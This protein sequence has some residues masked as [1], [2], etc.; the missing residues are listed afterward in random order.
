ML[1]HK[2]VQ[3]RGNDAGPATITPSKG[4]AGTFATINNRLYLRDLN[5][6][7]IRKLP[8]PLSS[9]LMQRLE[10][11]NAMVARVRYFLAIIAGLL[12]GT[13]AYFAL[14]YSL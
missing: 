8:R 14:G 2:T 7:R 9:H 4:P 6:T 3:T 1:L 10:Y 12:V 13:L 5:G 11:R